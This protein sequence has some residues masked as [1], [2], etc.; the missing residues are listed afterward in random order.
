[1]AELTTSIPL[2]LRGVKSQYHC[3]KKIDQD[4]ITLQLY[5]QAENPIEQ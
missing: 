2:V 1:M 3:R 5:H 4:S